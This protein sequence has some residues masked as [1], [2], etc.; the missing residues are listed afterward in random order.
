MEKVYRKYPGRPRVGRLLGALAA[1]G[2]A[3][4][5]NDVC[6]TPKGSWGQSWE[7]VSRS[8]PIIPASVKPES[9]TAL[10]KPQIG[11]LGLPASPDTAL[12]ATAASACV[13]HARA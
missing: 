11:E 9:T 4:Q 5:D 2:R 13:A 7:A 10:A 6:P 8:S 12:I 3:R 1:G